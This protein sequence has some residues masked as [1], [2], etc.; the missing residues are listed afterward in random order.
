VLKLVR[1]FPNISGLVLDDFLHWSA[2]SPPDPW[3]A[4]TTLGSVN[5]VLTPQH[6]WPLTEWRSCKPIGTRGLPI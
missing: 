6:R 4:P 1:A 3:L 2:D 5:L